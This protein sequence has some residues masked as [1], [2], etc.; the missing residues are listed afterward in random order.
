MYFVLL[1]GIKCLN[2]QRQKPVY[3]DTSIKQNKKLIQTTSKH[4]NLF[5]QTPL[6]NKIKKVNTDHL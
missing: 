6:Q 2:K 1:I 3:R 4:P 5:I